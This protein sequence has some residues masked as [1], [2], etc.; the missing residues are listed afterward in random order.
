MDK[1]E[2][3]IV[4]ARRGRL[5]VVHSEDG[6]RLRCEVRQKVVKKI[7]DTTPV[8]VGDDVLFKRTGKKGGVIEEVRTRR[9]AFVRPA[10][11]ETKKLQVIAANLDRLAAVVSV[12]SPPLRTGL[13]DRFLIAA[14]AGR[15]DALIIINKIDLE[16]PGDFEDIVS[17]YR[18]IGY[19][20]VTVS[21]LSGQGMDTLQKQLAGHRTLF[22]G[23]SGVGKST[24]LNQLIPGLNITTQEISDYSNRG[25]HTTTRVELYELPA[26]GFAV[27]S[28]GLKV[29][30]LWDI[31]KD[32]LPHY[33]PEFEP[34]RGACRFNPCSHTHEPDCEVK[35]ALEKGE[36]SR[37]RYEN[38]LAIAESL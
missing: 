30:G 31:N 13:I 9:T 7:E 36:I 18:A 20:V 12:A 26:G 11:G 38:Y 6:S 32:E 37:F 5:F 34:Y 4:V 28:P 14:R 29:M 8:A 21:A 24:L 22:V 10:K 25:K 17:T 15:M 27:D 33:Y 16:C 23:H 1:A 3:G 2:Q 35:K 19:P